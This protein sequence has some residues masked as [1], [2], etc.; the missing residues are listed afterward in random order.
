MLEMRTIETD[1]HMHS[2]FSADGED[3]PAALCRR[4]LELGFSEI[5]ITEH[6]EWH[7]GQA[8]FPQVDAY[9]AAIRSCRE[10][11]APQG[12]RVLSGV[13]LGNPHVYAAET[14]ALRAAY[15]FDLAIGSLHWLYGENI[16]LPACFAERDPYQVYA[17]YFTELARMAATAPVQM[18]AHFDRILWRGT[19]V[20]GRFHPR[21]VEGPI[22]RALQVIAARDLILELNTRFLDDAPNWNGALVTMLRWFRQEG[23]WRVAINS[24]AHR[25]EHMGANLD[26]ARRILEDAGL[27]AVTRLDPKEALRL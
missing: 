1:Y 2:I 22:R 20:D 23:G 24:D 8:G 11:F 6:A 13:E 10:E 18:I 26:I 12:L 21:R 19:A 4:A 16:H 27:D 15:P 3:P 25:I 7:K 9:F 17:D 5:A 14:A